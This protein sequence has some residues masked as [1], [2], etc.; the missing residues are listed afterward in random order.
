MRKLCLVIMIL[1]TLCT[2][3]IG[4]TS[5]NKFDEYTLQD[6]IQAYLDIPGPATF[7]LVSRET[8]E[9]LDYTVSTYIVRIPGWTYIVSAQ[10][11]GNTVHFANIDEA[12]EK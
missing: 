8:P 4:F 7:T 2:V 12:L 9:W 1:A 6:N 10:H 3:T 11:D 5:C